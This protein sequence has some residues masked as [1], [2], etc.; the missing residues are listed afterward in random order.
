MSKLE[1]L[2]ARWKLAKADWPSFRALCEMEINNTMLQ[3]DDPI[4]RF[5]TTLHK[6]SKTSTKSKKKKKPWF[7]DDCKISIQKRKQALQQLNAR[8]SQQN[9]ENSTLRWSL[10]GNPWYQV[11]IF[12]QG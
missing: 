7:N 4:Y 2:I 10:F 12:L 9:M 6:I 3:A 1:E 8:P 11:R 5:I